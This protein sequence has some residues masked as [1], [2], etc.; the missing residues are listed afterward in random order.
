MSTVCQVCGQAAPGPDPLCARCRADWDRSRERWRTAPPEW[1]H[2]TWGYILS[3]DAFIA[4]VARHADFTDRTRI[5]EVGPGYG[6]LLSACLD[7]GIPFAHYC[8]LDLSEEN[9]SY[10]RAR[11]PRPDVSFVQGDVETATLETSFDVVISSLTFKH[12]YPSFEAALRNLRRCLVPGAH[13]CIDFVEGQ[14][15]HFE[16]VTFNRWYSREEILDI[17]E[18]VGLEDCTFDQVEHDPEHVRLLLV[19][20]APRA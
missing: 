14:A 17:V 7:Q 16:G 20:R 8:G 9:C 12:L 5:L 11:F 2:L 10:L 1:D 3:G 13:V 4:T 15:Q 18:R 6:R 19:A